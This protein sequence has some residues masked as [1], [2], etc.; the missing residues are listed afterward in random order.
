[1]IVSHR[2]EFR[3]AGEP[4]TV[5]RDELMADDWYLAGMVVEYRNLDR[6][7][8]SPGRGGSTA[9]S[10]ATAGIENVTKRRLRRPQAS[11]ECDGRGHR[12]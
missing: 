2:Q 5:T 4:D 6:T 8:S 9:P 7:T 3:Q 12:G 1:M 10:R 11:A